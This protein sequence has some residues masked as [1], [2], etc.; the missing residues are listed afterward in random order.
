M[1]TDPLVSGSHGARGRD[2]GPGSSRP[3]HRGCTYSVLRYYPAVVHLSHARQQLASQGTYNNVRENLLL[4]AR[5][6]TEILY[7][8]MTKVVSSTLFFFFKS[9][10]IVPE[11][12][13]MTTNVALKC[14]TAST[15][16][17]E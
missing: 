1:S 9:L 13:V 14:V 10:I 6:R 7:Q 17:A 8:T 3:L 2:H 16:H 12:R 5:V 15:S 4:S 11:R